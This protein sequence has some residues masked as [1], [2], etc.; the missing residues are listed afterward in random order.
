MAG[1][2]TASPIGEEICVLTKIDRYGEYLHEFYALPNLKNIFKNDIERDATRAQIF[3]S[4][5]QIFSQFDWPKEISLV[6]V[7][8]G[9]V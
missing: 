5:N 1:R 2:M 9:I 3:Y 6:L 4:R 8:C 7:N